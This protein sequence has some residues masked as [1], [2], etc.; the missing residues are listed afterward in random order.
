MEVGNP[1]IINDVRI[2]VSTFEEFF[3][4]KALYPIGI[5]TYQRPYI[6]DIVKVKELINDLLVHLET[7]PEIPYYMGS[8]LLHQN[9]EK[10]KLF[11]IDGQQRLTT[12]SILFFILNGKL[13][14]DKMVMEY[15]SP[16][17]IQNIKNIQL[18]FSNDEKENWKE[19]VSLLF[20][21]IQFTFIITSSEDLAFTFFDTQNYRGVKLK[22]TDLL[23]AYHLRAIN[24][25]KL[26]EYCAKSW[27]NIQ[28]FQPLIGKKGDF[29]AEL[30][31]KY[32]WRARSW[33]GQK[34]ISLENDDGILKVFMSY[35]ISN[36]NDN[37]IRLFPNNNNSYGIKLYLK[38]N[39][40]YEIQL[41]KVN[42]QDDVNLPFLLRQPISK[43]LGY[44]LFS[45][46]YA[47][48]TQ[49]LFIERN[50]RSKEIKRFRE[51][52]NIVWKNISVYLKELFILAT[53]MYYDKF[54]ER[55]FFRFSLWLDHVLGAIRLEKQNVVKQAPIKFLME[56]D[57]NLLD[58]ISHAFMPEE[59]FEFLINCYEKIDIYQKENI[60]SGKGVQGYYKERL[61]TYYSKD[62]LKYKECWMEQL[63]EEIV[64]ANKV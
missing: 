16:I 7:E 39:K 62:S 60:E 11:I 6:W 36:D 44:F 59:V 31:N 38:D 43:G 24:N 55:E 14:N 8:I 10:K 49:L 51:F 30:I 26:Q 46:K 21:N 28:S 61:L 58:I 56:R 5:D 1:K 42:S 15:N 33:R 12:L 35:T 50:I 19:K 23:K 47:E 32:L 3:K 34:Q 40:D 2:H 27:E 17:S 29:A 25:L 48:I 53:I 64:Y 13:L 41:K 54:G 4:E 22:P 9:D 18:F 45:M 20:P 37:S 52:Y 63:I 57:N